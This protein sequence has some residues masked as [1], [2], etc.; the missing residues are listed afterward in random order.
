M[1]ASYTWNNMV[2]LS[3][4]PLNNLNIFRQVSQIV[5]TYPEDVGGHT[6]LPF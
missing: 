5:D 4:F 3:F 1:G 6:V 2:F